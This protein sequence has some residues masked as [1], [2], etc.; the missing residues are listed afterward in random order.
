MPRKKKT[1]GGMSHRYPGMGMP[2]EG[3]NL[4]MPVSI[5]SRYDQKL[6]AGGAPR[7]R[8]QNADII[9]T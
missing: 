6:N 7:N 3:V 8:I 5:R 9:P 4:S 2:N 1:D